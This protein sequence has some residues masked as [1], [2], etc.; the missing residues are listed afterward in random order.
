MENPPKARNRDDLGLGLIQVRT[1]STASVLVDVMF[2]KDQVINLAKLAEDRSLVR[3][4]EP[5]RQL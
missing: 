5:W 4:D 3:Y 1:F 2:T